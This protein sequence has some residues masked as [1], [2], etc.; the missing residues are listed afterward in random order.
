MSSGNRIPYTQAQAL[1][2][3]YVEI[4]RPFCSR[5]EVAGSIRRRRRDTSDIDIVATPYPVYDMFGLPSHDHQLNGLDWA[6]YNGSAVTDGPKK[7]QIAFLEI[8]LELHIV[9]PP[10]QWGVIY[11]LRTGP[12]D[13]SNA[14]V[15]P[16]NQMT[17]TGRRGLMPSYLHFTDGALY[18]GSQMIE[19]PEEEDVFR[20]LELDYIPPEMRK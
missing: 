14:I 15:T 11:L 3:Q 8:T 12:G 10:A 1:A 5:I 2:G 19:T 6:R 17:H 7:K 4:L 13:F 18:R 16:R 20:A 9:T